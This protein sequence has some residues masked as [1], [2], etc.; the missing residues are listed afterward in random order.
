M[1]IALIKAA[2]RAILELRAFLGD[3]V[4]RRKKSATPC[5]LRTAKGTLMVTK[6]VD[7]LDQELKVSG[8]FSW[9]PLLP[10]RVRAPE[11]TCAIPLRQL[12]NFWPGA[13]P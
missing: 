3:D 5:A 7:V 13:R 12:G 8:L 10:R 1:L 9:E 2:R 4:R 6:Q 11:P